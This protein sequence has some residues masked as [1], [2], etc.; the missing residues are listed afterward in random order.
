MDSTASHQPNAAD[1]FLQG[2]DKTVRPPSKEVD[3]TIMARN[4]EGYDP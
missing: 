2:A 1:K 3:G 4:K